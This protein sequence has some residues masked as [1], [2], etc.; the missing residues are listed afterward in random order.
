MAKKKRK[1]SNAKGIP[2]RVKAL[3]WLLV[4]LLVAGVAGVKFFQGSRGHLFLLG[5]GFTGYYAVSQ[6]EVDEALRRA[7]DELALTSAL[8][9]KRDGVTMRG[10]HVS[11]LVW[12]IACGEA[13]DLVKINLSLTRAARSRGASILESRE[14][15]DGRELLLEIGS[16]PYAT[17]KIVVST[18]RRAEGDSARARDA[19]P[20]VAIVIDDF[21]YS[22][23]GIV[24]AFLELDIPITCSVIPALPHSGR[25]AARAREAGKEVIL[26]LPMQPEEE[27]AYD[28][29][30]VTTAMSAAEIETMVETYLAG[31][32][33]IVGVNNH[34][35][36]RAT[37]DE[38]VMDAVLSVLEKRGLFFL[39]SLTSPRSIAYNAARRLGVKTARNDLFI[40]D[41]TQERELVEKRLRQL[42]ERARRH[43]TAIGIG[44]PHR[45]TLDALSNMATSPEHSDVRLVFLSEVVR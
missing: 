44:H 34:M 2:G 9:V 14:D 6:M 39:D 33:G 21:G 41:N 12:R 10:K 37:Q 23:N 35:G 16:G 30:P 15:R 29:E 19:R 22:Q 40:D 31:M 18:E 32:Q 24:K 42:I 20:I 28:V 17:H 25:L 43:G 3:G 5:R 45:W 13:C 36:S 7:V 27:W 8:T 4:I 1:T 38:R 26:H 11:L